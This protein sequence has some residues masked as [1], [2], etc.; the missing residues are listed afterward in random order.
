MSLLRD[1]QNA[2][3]DPNTDVATLLRKCKILAAR[4]RNDEFKLWLDH[5]LNGYTRIEDVPQYR[6]LDTESYG[7]FAGRFGRAVQNVPIPPLCLP[8]ELRDRA[9]RC[10]LTEPIG[11]Y[12][13]AVAS[14]EKRDPHEEWPADMT[15]LFA[16]KIYEDMN[17]LRAWK[18]IPYYG[19]VA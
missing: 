10:Y 3:V 8:E 14:E 16:Q 2:A 19:L 1:I 17:C 4:L 15:V 13:S 12:A 18:V 5:E 9:T 6:I 7:D 11:A